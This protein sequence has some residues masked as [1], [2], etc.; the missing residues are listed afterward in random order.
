MCSQRPETNKQRLFFA[1]WP[2]DGLRRRLK[3]ALKAVLYHS[4]GKPVPLEKL[5]ITLSFL[6]SVD[7]ATQHCIEQ[8]AAG[9]DCKPFTLSLDRIGY[10]PGPRVGWLGCSRQQETLSTLA[11]SLND[12]VQRCGIET[13]QRP[14]HTH[15]TL[16]RKALKAP[17]ITTID[18]LNWEVTGFALVASKTLSQGANYEVLRTWPCT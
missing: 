16:M 8:V 18:T 17:P 7:G 15:M 4:G 3:R 13:D 10:W 5:H 2:G 11:Y 12:G 9:I 1:L 6:G 14:F